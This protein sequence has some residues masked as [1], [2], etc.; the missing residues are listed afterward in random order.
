MRL[1]GKISF[2]FLCLSAALASEER[3]AVILTDEALSAINAPLIQQECGEEASSYAPAPLDDLFKKRGADCGSFINESGYGPS[4]RKLLKKFDDL[5]ECSPLLQSHNGFYKA[6]PR[7]G[8]LSLDERKN[9][10]VVVFAA[11]AWAES[12][13]RP[14]AKAAGVHGTAMGLLQLNGS[15]SNRSWRGKDCDVAE[16]LPVENNLRCGVDIMNDLRKETM[17]VYKAKGLFGKR[18]NSYWQELRRPEG[19]TIGARIKTFRPCFTPGP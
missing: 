15:R 16:I 10:W 19:G 6:C 11:I 18:S 13:C 2:F 7:W 3:Q 12:T 14:K 8:L 9:F 5:G 17:G 4:G 1:L